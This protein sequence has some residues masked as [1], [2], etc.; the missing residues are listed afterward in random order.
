MQWNWLTSRKLRVDI[1]TVF[2]FLMITISA[3]IIGH[4]YIKS[5]QV[6]LNLGARLVSKSTH[7]VIDS[8]DNY[9]RPTALIEAAQVMLSDGVLDEKDDEKLVGFMQIILQTHPQLAGA[10]IADKHNNMFS[11]SRI[12]NNSDLTFATAFIPKSDLFAGSQFISEV[13]AEHNGKM[14]LTSFFKDKNGEILSKKE[15]TLINYR[16][17]AQAWFQGAL[18]NNKKSWVALDKP[19]DVP[20]AQMT[21]A[22]SIVING[23]SVGVIAVDV[24]IDV[25]RSYLEQA[26]VSE[27]SMAFIVNSSGQVVTALSYALPTNEILPSIQDLHDARLSTAYRIFSLHHEPYFTFKVDGVEYMAVFVP[28]A[29]IG[30][31]IWEIA[32]IVPTEDFIGESKIQHKQILLFSIVMVL[33]GLLL[34]LLFSFRISKPI[35]NLAEDTQ[36]IKKLDFS[37]VTVTESHIYEIQVLT[38]AFNTAKNAL[39]SFVKYIP[40]ALIEKLIHAGTIAEVGGERRTVSI[41]FS[42][43]RNFTSLAENISAEILMAHISDYLNAVTAIIHQY[44]GNIDKF[45][46]DAVM[47]FWGAPLDDPDHVKHA[48]LAAL[49]CHYKIRQLNEHWQKLGKPILYTR[50]GLSTGSAVVGNM[51]SFDRLN[52]TTLG[53]EVNLASRLEQINK[54]YGTQIMVSEAVYEA[55]HKEFLF[56]PVDLVSVKGK[57]KRTAIYELVA[58]KYGDSE[59]KATSAQ[60]MLC[61]LTW[62]AYEAY[63]MREIERAVILFE[64]I[65]V[66]FPSDP[67]ATYYVKK[68]RRR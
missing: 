5:A 66:D 1:L 47:A 68:L 21:V 4:S 37:K 22:Q 14:Y 18:N 3:V 48:C 45:I 34:V 42:D 8:F 49:T 11:E 38:E 63:Q 56:R 28:Y 16:P 2:A 36:S 25:I 15:N 52:Y 43:I 61:D 24:S 50:F 46:G 26:K 39:S 67:V 13:I 30:N 35:M 29:S 40:K 53:D 57:V 6:M 60:L 9:I 23:H 19:K 54:I 64:E 65:L 58:V 31:N 33:I 62:E 59:L 17:N 41:L 44:Q 10:Y 32:T 12:Y 51:G 7:T 55:C 27:N 20:G